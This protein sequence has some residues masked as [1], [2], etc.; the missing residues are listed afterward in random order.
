MSDGVGGRA[1]DDLDARL[2]HGID[3]AVHPGVF[4]I[5]VFGLPQAPGRL[6]HADDGDARGLHQRDVFVEALVG[7]VFVVVGCAVEDV[8]EGRIR[9]DGF[10]L[11]GRRFCRRLL[12]MGR[13]GS[14]NHGDGC[15]K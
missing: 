14:N 11:S 1:H 3:D 5:A 9:R 13:S 4:E 10:S 6:A 12:G 7:H 15:Y 2:A 8:G